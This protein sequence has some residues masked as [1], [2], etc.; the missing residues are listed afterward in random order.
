LREALRLHAVGRGI[1][2][3]SIADAPAGTGLGSSGSFLV[4]LVHAL[5]AHKR[6]PAAAETLACEAIDIEMNRLGEPVGKQAKYLAACAR[7]T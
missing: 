1:E 2:I 3:V 7:L 5:H 6:Q 4:G